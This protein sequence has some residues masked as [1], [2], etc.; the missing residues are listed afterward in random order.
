MHWKR[1]SKTA[2]FPGMAA[3]KQNP[4]TSPPFDDMAALSARFLEKQQEL[5]G[6]LGH[7]TLEF[8]QKTPAQ[9][10]PMA[11]RE[12][13]VNYWTAALRDPGAILTAQRDMIQDY[14]RITQGTFDRMNGKT[15]E[16]VIPADKGDRRFR[17]PRWTENPFF[18]HMRQTYML[19]TRWAQQSVTAVESVDPAAARKLRFAARQYADALSPSNFW[20][21]NPEVLDETLKTRGE[22]LVRGMENLIADL[23]ANGGLPRVS[24][25]KKDLFAVGKNL[26]T[27][28]GRVVF[29]NDLVQI[30]QYE[31]A[32]KTVYKTPLVVVSPWINKYYI[33]DMTPENSFVKWAVEQGHTVFITSWA[34]A[35][36][37]L[38]DYGWFE[39]MEHGLRAAI[40]TAQKQTGE[41]TVNVIGYCIGGTLL[42]SMLA[43]DKARGVPSPVKSATYF[44]AMIDFDDAGELTLFTDEAQISTMETMMSEKGYLDA[45]YLHTTFN[46][47]RANDL[48]WSFVVNNYLLGREPFPFD[49]LH[50]NS[51]S[52][53][54]PAACHSFYL[55]QMYLHNNLAKPGKLV[56]NGTA[57]NVQDVDTPSYFIST[58][59]DHIAP[60]KS[61]YAGAKL[62]GGDVTFTLAGSGHIAGVV[63]HP[64]KNKYGFWTNAKLP[65]SADEWFGGAKQHDGSWWTNWAV[66]IAKHGGAKVSARKPAKGIE[67]APGSFVTVQAL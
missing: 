36:E 19:M 20:M 3:P 43:Y 30:I 10:D 1:A 18:D 52:T 54:I 58:V 57:L 7:K 51:D 27:T 44:T 45:W 64:T 50:W 17:D 37:R 23:R 60:W 66:W 41:K 16:P 55:R 63:N 67:A 47:L 5:W 31:P 49:L 56:L 65:N 48:I 39:Y 21:T 53:R 33:L 38:R 13:V 15:A 2:I 59:E 4:D 12:S 14:G 40:S 11:L 42:A 34:N 28:P 62:L 24:M 29:Q 61:T 35:D 32:T 22:N 25:V 6:L 9:Q 26:A 46:L 8:V